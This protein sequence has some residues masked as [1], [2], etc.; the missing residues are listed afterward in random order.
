[1]LTRSKHLEKLKDNN[2]RMRWYCDRNTTMIIWLQ[3]FPGFWIFVMKR[4]VNTSATN[5]VLNNIEIFAVRKQFL[6]LTT[7]FILT[8][9]VDF[10]NGHWRFKRKYGSSYSICNKWNTSKTKTNWKNTLSFTTYQLNAK[11]EQQEINNNEKKTQANRS[12]QERN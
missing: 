10:E 8:K 5:R 2:H 12:T 9:R 6:I 3:K 7:W 4:I 1:M 11:V